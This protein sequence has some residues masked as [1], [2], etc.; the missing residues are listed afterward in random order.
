MKSVEGDA[1]RQ[2]DVKV[3]R[4]IVDPASSE[5]PGKILEQEVSVFEEPQHAEVDRDTDPQPDAALPGRLY[6][7][8][9][10]AEIKI[11][12]GG[13]KQQRSERRVPRAIENIARD[14]KEVLTRIPRTHAPVQ[15][16]HN[17]EKGD[18]GKRVKQH[19]ACRLPA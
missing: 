5:N 13:R 12:S 17:H 19:R 1:D 10:S 8:H 11:E 15:A 7:T 6:F 4:L 3:R 14:E 2:K 9:F 18:K 16:E